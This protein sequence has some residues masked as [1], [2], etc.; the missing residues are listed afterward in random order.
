M[1]SQ[2]KNLIIFLVAILFVILLGVSLIYLTKNK[3]NY[4]AVFLNDGAI[5]FGKLST[6]PKLK[7]DDAIFLQV[8]Q[9]GQA[10]FQRFKDA[11]WMPKGPIYL[12]QNSILFIAPLGENSPLVN[13]IEQRQV[14]TQIPQQPQPP[15]RPSTSTTSTPQQ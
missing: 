15:T 8:D 6:F 11:F 4:Y 1:K 3:S 14:P 5:Y 12:N 13:L 7:L 2:L 10:S 9:Q